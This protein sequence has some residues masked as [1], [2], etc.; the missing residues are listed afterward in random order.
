MLCVPPLGRPF[1]AVCPHGPG[2]GHSSPLCPARF[3]R[4][5]LQHLQNELQQARE[6]TESCGKVAC[7]SCEQRGL[8]H[9]QL[10]LEDLFLTEFCL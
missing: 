8:E 3:S 6:R 5:P 7:F 9:G 1:P 10:A 4:S 2:L